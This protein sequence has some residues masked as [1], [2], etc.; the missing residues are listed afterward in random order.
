MNARKDENN[1][2]RG[3]FERSLGLRPGLLNCRQNPNQI[4]I[5]CR[6]YSKK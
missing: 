5:K 4:S 2:I 1:A 6:N 3:N